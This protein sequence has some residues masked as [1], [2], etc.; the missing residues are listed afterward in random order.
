M[1]LLKET[2][3]VVT[4]VRWKI[5]HV[6]ATKAIGPGVRTMVALVGAMSAYIA[7]AQ[8]TVSIYGTVDLSG[9]YVKNEGSEARWSLARD[10]INNSQ[11]G[12][13]AVEDLGDGLKAGVELLASVGADV[14]DLGDGQAAN[15]FWSRRSNVFLSSPI[16]EIRLGREYT[17]TFWATP[18]YDAFGNVGVGASGRVLQMTTSTFQRA[19]NSI[20]YFLPSA[21]GGV[22][23]Q[24]M[25][26]AAEGGAAANATSNAGRYVGLRL[27]F[28]QGP[29]DVSAATGQQRN[30]YF[31]S[32]Q[33][34]YNA[35]GRYDLG[36]LKVLGYVVRD[37]AQNM[38]ETRASISAVIPLGAGEIHLGYGRSRL[39][40]TA[41][42]G[43]N[44]EN[45]IYHIKAGYQHNLSK[46]TALYATAGELTNGDR[47]SF[48]VA[49]G[50]SISAPTKLG[51]TSRGF[52]VGMRHFF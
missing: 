19:D 42:A 35:G 28:A 4:T 40:N 29:L 23:G 36:G 43:A 47:S 48:A 38:R 30:S 27:G 8:S 18:L 14:G 24:A 52:E 33:R 11:L 7:H 12:I 50:T 5:S 3:L 46:R 20:S 32:T 37:S 2:K 13:R 17:P 6:G 1:D 15:K 22:Y 34:T 9:K 21:L 45:T 51:G 39:T 26:A 25:V 10:G 49:S 41:L 31:G 16:G 44:F